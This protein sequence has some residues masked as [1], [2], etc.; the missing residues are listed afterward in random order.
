MSNR[1]YYFLSRLLQ[2]HRL[3]FGYFLAVIV[4]MLSADSVFAQIKSQIP[5]PPSA[6]A[7]PQPNAPAVP[8]AP[9]P[10]QASE[11]TPPPVPSADQPKADKGFFSSFFGDDA[12]DNAPEAPV[13]EQPPVPDPVEEEPKQEA[14]PKEEA[15][16]VKKAE[17]PT[18][19]DIIP[20]PKR[21]PFQI[22]Q[23]QNL[24]R[25]ISKRHYSPENSHLPPAAYIEEH[26]HLL[27]NAI[28][29]G[30]VPVVRSLVEKYK[31]IDVRDREGN[32]PLLYATSV[33]N[34]QLVNMLVGMY[35]DPN[36][37]N[38]YLTTPLHVAAAGGRTDLTTLLLKAGS[39]ANEQD[40]SGMTPLMIAA[41][42]GFGG[43]VDLLLNADAKIGIRRKDGNTALHLA[44]ITPNP[45]TCYTLLRRGA[46]TEYR[47]FE[48]LTPLMLAA[49]LGN[50]QTVALLLKAGADTQATDA[51]GRN[52]AHLATS[53]GY[54]DLALTIASEAVRR[55]KLAEKIEDIRTYGRYQP[56][57]EPYENRS[58]ETD[59]IT[60]IV[61]RRK[62]GIP[63]PIAK[64]DISHQ[65][66]AAQPTQTQ[67]GTGYLPMYK[68]PIPRYM[69]PAPT[70]YGSNYPQMMQ[71]QQQAMTKNDDVPPVPPSQVPSNIPAYNNAPPPPA[72]PPQMSPDS[73]EPKPSSPG[74][75]DAMRMFRYF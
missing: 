42:R 48:G 28:A 16:K 24:P 25:T 56:P 53:S 75:S 22:Y 49:K 37:H 9:A 34:V 33:G 11:P 36:V 60:T 41:E 38:V 18:I 15:K 3:R 6:P 45:E 8:P 72:M 30:N 52:A 65:K 21:K 64:P 50:T 27:F 10:Q 73:L 40:Q 20:V 43:V 47:N 68:A 35:A 62:N 32:T 39:L 46:N 5:D 51:S 55:E 44:C 59:S 70:Y 63:L 7:L 67:E 69:P 4:V 71:Q 17:G 19:P 2:F 12:E 23:S 26:V 31:G 13:A 74:G 54:N 57:P 14:A 58:Y 1:T 29:H 61:A 66:V